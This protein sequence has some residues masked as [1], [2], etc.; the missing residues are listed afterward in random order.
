[1]FLLLVVGGVGEYSFLVF[2]VLWYGIFV[3]G[4]ILSILIFW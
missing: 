2:D 4:I 1:M 3:V